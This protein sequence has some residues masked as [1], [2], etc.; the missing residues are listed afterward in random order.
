MKANSQQKRCWLC[1]CPEDFHSL[2]TTS[3]SPAADL[4]PRRPR[5]GAGP[6]EGRTAGGASNTTQLFLTSTD[7]DHVHANTDTAS[8]G[9]YRS[10]MS[11]LPDSRRRPT[12]TRFTSL[13]V[14]AYDEEPTPQQLSGASVDQSQQLSVVVPQVIPTFL[15]ASG[16]SF[17]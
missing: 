17:L 3:L 8:T 6:V 15:K 4:L 9:R 1:L 2:Q 5:E 10:V 7:T 14:F 16:T 12:P 13:R 11:V